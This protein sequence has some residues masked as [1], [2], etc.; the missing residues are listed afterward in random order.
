MLLNITLIINLKVVPINKK[1]L[2]KII[3]ILM[4]FLSKSCELFLYN[5]NS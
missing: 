2:A 4:S 1:F 3:L 5:K